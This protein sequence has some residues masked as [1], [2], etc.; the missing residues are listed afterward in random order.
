M[1]KQIP[2]KT[3]GKMFTPCQYCVKNYGNGAWRA[4]ACSLECGV[5]YFRR[6]EEARMAQKEPAVIEAHEETVVEKQETEV[7]PE[8]EIAEESISTS[9]KRKRKNKHTKD[10]TTEETEDNG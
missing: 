8:M 9:L 10:I 1:A 6:V 3:C 2:C 7:V 5:E 4:V